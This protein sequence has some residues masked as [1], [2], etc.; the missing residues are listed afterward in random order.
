[1]N[2]I[3][4]IAVLFS[5]NSLLIA[6]VSGALA[7]LLTSIMLSHDVTLTPDGWAYWEGSVSLRYFLEL[8]ARRGSDEEKVVANKWLSHYGS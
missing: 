6:G 4:R 2:A 7:I 8:V 3:T 1:M 5:R